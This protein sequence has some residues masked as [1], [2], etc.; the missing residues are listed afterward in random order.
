MNELDSWATSYICK[1]KS[2]RHT[3][4]QE[5]QTRNILGWLP[6][7]ISHPVTLLQYCDFHLGLFFVLFC[8]LSAKLFSPAPATNRFGNCFNFLGNLCGIQL[9]YDASSSAP[10]IMSLLQ[11]AKGF[12]CVLWE[13]RREVLRQS[14]D[15]WY[16]LILCSDRNHEGLHWMIFVQH[17]HQRAASNQLL[18]SQC[19]ADQ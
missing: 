1:G 12:L 9:F 19:T 17:R 18:Q 8:F 6:T 13:E 4:Q 3:Y 5:F 14:P 10:K 7:E 2:P 16:L 11:D 15:L